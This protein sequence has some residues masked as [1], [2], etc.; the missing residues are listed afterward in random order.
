MTFVEILDHALLMLR[1]IAQGVPTR[2]PG[3]GTRA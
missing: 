1:G 3:T 2:P